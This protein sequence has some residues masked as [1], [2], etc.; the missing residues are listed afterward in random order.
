[1]VFYK[2]PA[3]VLL[4]CCYGVWCCYGLAIMVF[5]KLLARVLLW[6]FYGVAMVFLLWCC[7]GVA[8]VRCVAMVFNK[9]LVEG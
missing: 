1:M 7:Y 2:F 9:F 5:Y 6:C 4:K 3:M 8:I